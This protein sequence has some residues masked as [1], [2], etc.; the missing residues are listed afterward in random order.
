MAQRIALVTGAQGITGRAI[1]ERL[2]HDPDWQVIALSRRPPTYPSR[3]RFLSAEL[4]DPASCT[5]I[6]GELAAV[7]HVFFC[8][9]AP[10]PSVAAEI[11]P[12]VAMLANLMDAL[13]P[14][15]AGLQR[16]ELMHGAK[17]YGS[18]LG[19]Y[20]TP[21][22]EDDPRPVVEN[23]YHAQQDWLVARQAGKRWQWSAL[24]PHG[25]WGF[26]IGGRMNLMTGLVLYAAISKHLGLAL[27]WPG[28]QSFY[29]CLYNIIDTD[30][31]AEA[32][33]WAAVDPAAANDA[34]NV[35]NGDFF[36]WN[37]V[38][39]RIAEFFDMAVGPV[40][41]LSLQSVMADKE[42]L[43]AEI[44]ARHGL[45][46]YTLAELTKWDYIDG[47]L[48]NG[49]DQMSSTTKARKAGWHKVLD[50][51]ATITRQLQRLRDSKIIP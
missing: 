35:S 39:P 43:W 12:N 2:D 32:M 9:Y 13:E 1:V 49:Y 16:V 8:A 11:A 19:P 40:Q 50:T 36:R 23:F 26:S 25:I 42:P 38:W 33:E 34:F 3:A 18:Y 17:W 7:T 48:A 28:K 44:V 46:P 5:A 47:A 37:Q 10:K 29:D 20:R 6:A 51:E 24:R 27:R 31:L 14:V 45:K 30:L 15:A 22:K 4:L 21:A 41:T